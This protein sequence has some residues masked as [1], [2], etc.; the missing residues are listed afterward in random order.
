MARRIKEE[1]IVHRN[2]IAD[3]AIKLFSKKGIYDTSM[4]DIAKAS[5]Y[6]K[7]TLYVYFQNKE[8]IISFIEYKSM[9]ILCE[10]IRK[11]IDENNDRKQ[12]FLSICKALTEYREEYPDFFEQSIHNISVD[13]NSKSYIVGEEINLLLERYINDGVKT[14]DFNISG[15]SFEVTFQL[16][17]MISG[18]I[19]LA[20]E[21]EEYIMSAGKISKEK[22]LADSFERIYYS[23]L[24]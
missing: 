21:K 22:F 17:G 6:S 5:G 20:C 23:T 24:L 10:A 13:V 11:A 14:G 15:S 12:T 19:N 3:E 4:D 18:I 7:A 9:E 16:W 2:R 1:P 8:E